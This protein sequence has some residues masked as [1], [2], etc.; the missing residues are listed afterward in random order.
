MANI[1]LKAEKGQEQLNELLANKSYLQGYEP[2]QEDVAAFNQLNKAPSDKFP[3]LLRWYKHISSFSDAEK[4]G[5]PGI[6]TSASKEED[7]DVDLFGS[8]EEDEEAEKIKAERMKAYSDKK[9]KK[10]AIVAKSSVI[11]DIK[12]WDDETDMAEMEKLV[13]SVQMDGLVWGA[14]K[15]IPLA[16]GIKKLSI[17]C[18][19]EDDKV[20]IDELQEKISEFEDFVQS[21]D[22]AAFNKV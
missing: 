16:Y 19:V 21:V 6:P 3:Y 12:P 4:K 2:S 11:L 7:D 14:A 13:R 18:V 10:P 20:S 17:M 9:S 8:D 15:L 1:D 22:I 5:F